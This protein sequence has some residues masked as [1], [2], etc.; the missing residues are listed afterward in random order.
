MVGFDVLATRIWNL[1]VFMGNFKSKIN[2]AVHFYW[3]Y[4]DSSV[5]LDKYFPKSMFFKPVFPKKIYVNIDQTNDW[6][7]VYFSLI[8]YYSPHLSSSCKQKQKQVF[9]EYFQHVC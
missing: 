8:K 2:S 5:F 4:Q 3:L 1:N 9:L 7:R 6:V